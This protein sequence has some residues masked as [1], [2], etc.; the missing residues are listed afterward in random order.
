MI[1]NYKELVR[2]Y[3]KDR[4]GISNIESIKD[5]SDENG[6]LG[7]SKV[8]LKDGNTVLAYFHY[9]RERVVIVGEEYDD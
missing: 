3:V 9:Q 6:I 7:V 8:K 2:Q 4:Y 1:T 5:I